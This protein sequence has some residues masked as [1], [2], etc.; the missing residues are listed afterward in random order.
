MKKIL[1]KFAILVALVATVLFSSCSKN[2]DPV[3]VGVTVGTGPDGGVYIDISFGGYNGGGYSYPNGYPRN[4]NQSDEFSFVAYIWTN[5]I[6]RNNR[7]VFDQAGKTLLGPNGGIVVAN[8]STSMMTY[9]QYDPTQCI[10]VPV[11]VTM[12]R[13]NNYKWYYEV[14]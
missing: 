2:S 6:S 11:V 9:L 13:D 7:P 8:I 3:P 4:W 5:P 10:L 14:E 1:N 12:K